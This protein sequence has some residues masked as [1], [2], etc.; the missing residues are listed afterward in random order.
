MK[1]HKR[2]ERRIDS[3]I[4]DVRER[5]WRSFN[6]ALE[7]DDILSGC[8]RRYG[9]RLG[10]QWIFPEVS[11]AWTVDEPHVLVFVQAGKGRQG[12]GVTLECRKGARP[13]TEERLELARE[14]LRVRGVVLASTTAD[15]SNEAAIGAAV[16]ELLGRAKAAAQELVRAFA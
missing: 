16:P 3:E 15:L 4:A 10:F 5:F 6:Q 12:T 7:V 1:Q 9:G 2:E 11:G 8:R 14:A 13:E